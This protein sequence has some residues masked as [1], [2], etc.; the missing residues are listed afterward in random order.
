MNLDDTEG[1]DL[2]YDP[3][4][5]RVQELEEVYGCSKKLIEIVKEKMASKSGI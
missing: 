4:Y 3:N 2:D 5:E 1:V